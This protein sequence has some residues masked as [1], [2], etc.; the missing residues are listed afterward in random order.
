MKKFFEEFKKFIQRGNVIDLAVGVIIGSAFSKITSSMVNDIIMPL[1][2]AIFGLFGVKGGVA[3]MSLVLNGVEKYV[4]D[5]TTGAWVLNPEAILWNY[6]N[7]IQAILDF[8]LIALVLFVI[9]KAINLANDELKKV[10][11]KSPFTREELKA[12]RK[13]GLSRKEIK[14][15]EAA[16]IAEL[17]EEAKRAAEEAAANAPKTEQELLAEIVELLQA[18]KQ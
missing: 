12:F 4:K 17:E 1:I 14:A 15:K 3:G 5:E 7:F 6:G 11:K 16:R 9:I 18:Q 2:T 13:Q 10:T 8:L